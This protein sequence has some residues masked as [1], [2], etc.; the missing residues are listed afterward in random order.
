MA[1]TTAAGADREQRENRLQSELSSLGVDCK[2]KN[3][4]NDKE[5]LEALATAIK[6]VY[7]QDYKTAYDDDIHKEIDKSHFGHLI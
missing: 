5:E 6:E 2:R 1:P 3:E 7:F 4:L